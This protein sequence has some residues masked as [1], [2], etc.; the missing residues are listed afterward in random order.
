MVTG[1][2]RLPHIGSLLEMG[3]GESLSSHAPAALAPPLSAVISPLADAVL[4]V[5]PH[6]RDAREEAEEEA[7]DGDS[8]VDAAARPPESAGDGGVLVVLGH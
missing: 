6:H 2:S 1:A 5:A 8:R 4:V 3:T 7:D